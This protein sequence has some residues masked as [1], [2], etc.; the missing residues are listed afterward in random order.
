ME[1]GDP[2]GIQAAQRLLQSL[3]QSNLSS[4]HV[5]GM[6]S[7]GEIALSPSLQNIM[8]LSKT[9]NVSMRIKTKGLEFPEGLLEKLVSRK[10]RDYVKKV[11]SSLVAMPQRENFWYCFKYPE[12]D[13][14]KNHDNPIMRFYIDYELLSKDARTLEYLRQTVFKDYSSVYC[15]PDFLGM[16]DVRLSIIADMSIVVTLLDF[17]LGIDGIEELISSGTTKGSNLG[18]VLSLEGV[19]NKLT[20]TNDILDIQKTLGLE[21]ARNAIFKETN[22][23]FIADYMTRRG[24]LVSFTKNNPDVIAK[25]PLMSMAFERPKKDIKKAV[26][27]QETDNITSV[28]SQIMLHET[29]NTGTGNKD[30][31]ITSTSTSQTHHNP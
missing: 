19:D 13:W 23:S 30:F 11:G 5:A 20:I 10:F 6:S 12:K 16:I 24:Y 29:P 14:P 7:E 21:A 27:Y 4:F 3:T 28:Y 2:I 18:K 22:N 15:S 8:D 1:P 26:H 17:P 9:K 25:G 31:E